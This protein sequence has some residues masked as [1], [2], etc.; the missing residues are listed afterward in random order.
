MF[1]KHLGA[2]YK[3]LATCALAG[4]MLLGAHPLGA[5]AN[6][7][8]LVVGMVPSGGAAT[9]LPHAQGR[10]TVTTAEVGEN[11]HVEFWGLPPNTAFDFFETQIPNPPFGMA[12]YQ[13]DIET[14][15]RG[16]GVGDFNGIF[17]KE[18]FIVAPGTRPAPVV[19]GGPFSDVDTN[20]TTGPVHTYH[21]GLW[22]NAPSGAARA[23]CATTL[24]PFNGE[25]TAG[26]Q[27]LSTR[28]YPDL[29]GPLFNAP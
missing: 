16:V 27:A 12:W 4:A 15:S 3:K 20:P 13:G 17:S 2:S 11:M 21:L 1:K 19:F 23:G 25:H 10:V 29:R 18:T 24:T 26:I 8:N 7:N 14:D 6:G 5:Q 9:C 22:F 28:N